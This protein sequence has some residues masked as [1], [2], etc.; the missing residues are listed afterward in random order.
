MK[1]R[2]SLFLLVLLS[3]QLNA[4]EVS[5]ARKVAN[6][7]SFAK[8]YGYVRY[9]HPS[10]EAA[11][12]DWDQF[13]YYGSKTVENAANTQ[14]LNQK[15]NALFN[16]VAPSVR[17]VPNGSAKNFDLKSIT[18]PVK[19]G[20]KEITW[21][22]YGL[23]NDDGLYKSVRTNRSIAVK[24]PNRAKFGVTTN[25]VDAKSH[26]G[27]NFRLKGWMKTEVTSGQGQMWMRVDCEDQKTGFF[28]NMDDRPVKEKSWKAYEIS[29]VVDTD[30]REFVFGAF[31]IG[32]GKLWA[33]NFKLEVE[34]KGAWTPVPLYNSSFEENTTN[35]W[36][37]GS[38]GYT[39]T[40]VNDTGVDGQK[41]LLIATSSETKMITTIFDT[42][43]VFGSYF[44]KSIG[45]GLSCIVPQVLM[46]T[47]TATY[48]QA[49]ALKLQELKQKMEQSV[50]KTLPAEDLYV[51]LSAVAVSW[52]VFQ[53]FFPYR[54]EAKM[55]WNKEL[56]SALSAAYGANNRESFGAVLRVMTEKLKDGHVSVSFGQQNYF[57]I[58]A[59]AAFA[60]GKIL[61]SK[62]DS[63]ALVAD[64][65]PM[66][67]G[68]IVLAIDGVPALE[69]FAQ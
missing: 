13:L 38:K 18:P 46:G 31:L 60:E 4:Q 53:H 12:L 17:I 15:L 49:N 10:E 1:Q 20:M 42:K 50:P 32:E 19:K 11:K 39:Y 5:K 22:H 45:N 7:E 23:G 51:R 36:Y 29:G 57:S 34:D 54:E 68:D 63:T 59:D 65:L 6:I 37:T 62:V 8:L 64:Q 40:Q 56:P 30:A 58:Q 28:N 9:F 67:A 41:A 16:P 35:G 33:D 3:A 25:H 61:I 21:Q 43:P 55:E 66:K 47:E 69:Y 48:P 26:R 44:I 2:L 27:K 52:N 14:E 24:D